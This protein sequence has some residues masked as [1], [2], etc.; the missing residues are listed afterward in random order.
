LKACAGAESF[1]D[2]QPGASRP[3]L[4]AWLP[5][6]LLLAALGIGAARLRFETDVLSLLPRELDAVRGLQLYEKHFAD[7]RELIVT[8]EAPTAE[9][10]EY[11]AAAMASA[12]PKEMPGVSR[13]VWQQAL[14][15]D[16]QEA[17]Q[18]LGCLW[19]NQPPA[20]VAA[21]AAR[22]Q[23]GSLRAVAQRAREQLSTTLSPMDMAAGAHD[24]FGLVRLS[25][26]GPP[27]L[28]SMRTGDE[29]FT[30][31]DGTFRVM[32][33]QFRTA[34]EDY[35][36]CRRLLSAFGDA[37]R[38]WRMSG[39]IPG[40]VDVRCTGRPAFVAEISSSME[41]DM[42]GS[43]TGT[44][45]TIGLLFW[46]THR[47]LRPLVW[48]L[49]VLLGITA[50]TLALGGLVLGSLNIVSLGFA[51]ILLGLA[52]DFGILIYQES[53]SHPELGATGLRRKVGPGIL[54]SALST[55]GAFLALSLSRLPGL[56]QLGTLVALGIALAAGIM[57]FIYPPVLL[58]LR[59]SQD[60][61]PAAA[62]SERFLLFQ[63]RAPLPR[64]CSQGLTAVLGVGALALLLTRGNSIDR[65]PEAF[66]PQNSQ[67]R[68][69]LNRMQTALG[70]P[71]NPTWLMVKGEEVGD[72]AIRLDRI[73]AILRTAKSVGQIEGWELPS[74]M[75]PQP[76]RQA[77]N[78]ETLRSLAPRWN[79]FEEAA[80]AE[81][82]TDE[83]L[84]LHHA[85]LNFWGRLP[86][87]RDPVWPSGDFNRWVLEKTSAHS[88]AGW[89]ALGTIREVD[90]ANSKAVTHGAAWMREVREA[91][92]IVSG[93][94]LLG[95]AAFEAVK[96]DL[97]WMIGLVGAL[98]LVTLWLAFRAWLD[99]AL[100]LATLAFSALLLV[101]AM[102]W[103]GWSWNLMNLV[104][105][106]LLLGMGVD[107]S[108]HMQLALREHAGDNLKVRGSTGRALLLAG[109][110]TVA[111]FA[112]LAFSS[113]SGMASLG[114]TCALGIGLTL[115]TAIYLLPAWW[116]PGRRTPMPPHP[117]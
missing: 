7:A 72:V 29:Y 59:R 85:L 21:L 102:G 58:R 52:E 43:C 112:S 99:V 106:P 44:L 27:G 6:A 67:A 107:F 81:G 12:L 30:S 48:L 17:A 33:V 91:G 113:N 61:E 47:R 84:Q 54:W 73:E 65:S 42:A 82:F 100:S 49:A 90:T 50:G 10:A 74:V 13:V 68:A 45:A 75:W 20:E 89:M 11:A 94:H 35:R 62:G 66:E 4:R 39:L 76:E 63:P 34:L 22:L 110:T 25:S 2:L 77:A 80:R 111:G 15:R 51:A 53:R 32:F 38:G 23:P 60:L 36:D 108:I 16:T 83:A 24:P 87:S 56:A 97:R 86:E 98:V 1:T 46:L 79:E 64:G 28:G 19:L 8:I 103:M 92:G 96:L 57:L 70:L 104:A 18:L 3:I 114:R 26:D 109:S 117:S 95:D 14:A 71:A 93:W 37:L 9:V 105:V 41:K 55:A 101:A 69:A 78:R 31:P 5:W 40:G 115:F 116:R 88:S